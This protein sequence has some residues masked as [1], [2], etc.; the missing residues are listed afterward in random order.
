M[1]DRP[2]LPSQERAFLLAIEVAGSE[3]KLANLIGVSQVAVNKAKHRGRCSAE[4]AAAIDA[5]LAPR[6]TK[7]DLRPDL[8]P[9]PA[10]QQEAEH[11]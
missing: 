1:D 9:E 4:M 5:A 3:F 8:W 11:A 2:T 6:V 7:H 10:R